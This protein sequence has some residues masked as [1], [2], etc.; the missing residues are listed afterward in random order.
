[1][2]R[3]APATASIRLDLTVLPGSRPSS[4]GVSHSSSADFQLLGTPRTNTGHQRSVTTGSYT[5]GNVESI[6]ETMDILHT[7]LD[8]ARRG[9]SRK[10]VRH[11]SG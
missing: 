8:R 1:M 5:A 10:A 4:W 7:S 3:V 9:L 6:F 2:V 11:S